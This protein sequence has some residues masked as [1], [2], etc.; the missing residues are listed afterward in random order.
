MP[1]L[2]STL[3]LVLTLSAPPVLAQSPATD[4]PSA[5]PK[6]DLPP[7]VK[8]QETKPHAQSTLPRESDIAQA[9]APA[10][11]GTTIGGYGELTLNAPQGGPSVVDLRRFVLFFGHSFSETL[12]FSSE[13]EV[14][15][16]ISS[17]GDQGEVEIEQAFLD[18][19]LRRG[20]NLR[21]GL[22]LMPVGII[23]V[24]HEPP[25]FNSVDRPLVD[26][27]IIPSTWR[28]PG[29]GI[30]G[31]VSPE[32][33][34]QL[35]VVN[36]FNAHGFTAHNAVREGH[37]EAQLAHAS[38]VAA[39]ARIDYEPLLGLSLGVSG[40]AGTSGNTLKPELGRIP[41][42]MAEVDLRYRRGGFSLR[43]ELASVFI[44]NAAGLSARLAADEETAGEGPV[45]SR[46]QGGYLELGYDLLQ[47]L[48]T[49][50][51]PSLTLFGRAEVVDTQAAVPA[52]FE[53][54]PE[55]KRTIATVG[56]AFRPLPKIAIKADYK[57]LGSAAEGPG[58]NEGAAGVAWMF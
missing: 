7:E 32:V 36:G 15:H 29:F 35:Y 39:V 4:A 45:S 31:E 13:V 9:L 56:L 38:D 44:G 43:L 52:G 23:N 49:P 40:Y 27:A 53:A 30:F 16:A 51:E 18:V 8:S 26:T 19:L 17:A 21:V 46:S 48:P 5:G 6:I 1:T 33:R 12:R 41:V 47:L 2:K 24:F 54:R 55:L 37:Q 20:I 14:E 10:P 58:S 3:L 25:T 42:G 50:V 11:A 34:Y 22:L 57:R 28:E